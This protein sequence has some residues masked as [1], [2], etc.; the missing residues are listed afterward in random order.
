MV[1]DKTYAEVAQAISDGKFVY[2]YYD[3]TLYDTNYYLL[4]TKKTSS[5]VFFDHVYNEGNSTFKNKVGRVTISLGSNSIG[6]NN[7]N[8]FGYPN[9]YALSCAHWHDAPLY[10]H[11]YLQEEDAFLWY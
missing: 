8:V 6:T 9:L 5:S 10:N 4:P 1:A 2:G 7:C 11:V 3:G